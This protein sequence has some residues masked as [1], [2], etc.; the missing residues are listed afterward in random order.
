M[1]TS[2]SFSVWLH[3]ERREGERS[4]KKY[5]SFLFYDTTLITPSLSLL[6]IIGYGISV[7]IIFVMA[8]V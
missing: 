6:M 1:P 3:I 8:S 7:S 5:S 4:F 2:F